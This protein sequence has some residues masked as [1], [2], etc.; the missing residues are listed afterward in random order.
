MRL[1]FLLRESSLLSSIL[2]SLDGLLHLKN[3]TLHLMQLSSELL[4]I[5]VVAHCGVVRP[6][7]LTVCSFKPCYLL[8]AKCKELVSVATAPKLDTL[9]LCLYYCKLTVKM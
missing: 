3:M 4:L 1:L 8:V 6:W 7:L 9:K 5:A 2:L